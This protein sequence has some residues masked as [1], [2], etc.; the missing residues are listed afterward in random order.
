MKQAKNWKEMS[1]L[2]IQHERDRN[3]MQSLIRENQKLKKENERLQEMIMSIS[4]HVAKRGNYA[5]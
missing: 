1:L 2:E 5:V 4:S 3:Q